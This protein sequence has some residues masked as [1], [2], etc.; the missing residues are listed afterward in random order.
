MTREGALPGVQIPPPR[1]LLQ[2]I[3]KS[4]HIA[5]KVIFQDFPVILSEDVALKLFPSQ[6]VSPDP[7]DGSLG[8]S[9]EWLL[10]HHL[11]DLLIGQ[12]VDQVLL[13]L[14]IQFPV[15]IILLRALILELFLL[16]ILIT[17]GPQERLR[18][19]VLAR[20]VVLLAQWES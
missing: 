2:H 10:L 16:I 8:F 6:L 20:I 17:I 13:V 18:Q 12:V 7:A 3:L 9:R 5:F 19:E 14:G 15:Q 1:Y 4:N 11:V